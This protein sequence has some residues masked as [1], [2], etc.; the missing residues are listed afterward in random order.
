MSFNLLRL[1]N[2]LDEARRYEDLYTE[3]LES[4]QLLESREALAVEEAERIT[5]RTA[6]LMGH[7]NGGQKISYVDGVRREMALVKQVGPNC[8]MDR[9]C[10]SMKLRVGA[11]FDPDD[12]EWCELSDKGI[13][14]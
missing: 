11:S 2:A 3:L 4:H 12:V 10:R 13:D 14:R 1:R 5:A 6:E 9:L 7:G 8:L